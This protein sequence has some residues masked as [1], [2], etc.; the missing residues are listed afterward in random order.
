MTRIGDK[1]NIVRL[2]IVCNSLL[3]ADVLRSVCKTILAP[4]SAGS[5]QDNSA[6]TQ[7]TDNTDLQTP[8]D[9]QTDD[10]IARDSGTVHNK[11]EHVVETTPTNDAGEWFSIDRILKQ[12]MLKIDDNF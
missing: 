6:P 3:H 10:S 4:N 11:D 12:R 7:I 1:D 9:S 8:S 2:C 5:R